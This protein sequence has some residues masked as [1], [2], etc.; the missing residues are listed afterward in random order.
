[1]AIVDKTIVGIQILGFLGAAKV[2]YFI[3]VAVTII[4]V[5]TISRPYLINQSK[6][7]TVLMVVPVKPLFILE[8]VSWTKF[9][10]RLSFICLLYQL[11]RTNAPFQRGNLFF[12]PYSIVFFSCWQTF[13]ILRLHVLLIGSSME[14]TS[15]ILN[16]F[17][18]CTESFTLIRAKS[19]TLIKKRILTNTVTPILAL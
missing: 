19:V 18:D 14:N 12:Q 10:C 16:K 3:D 17:Q 6:T 1:M 7:Q 8:R 5:E 13:E 4:N 9:N 15:I 2:F 11:H